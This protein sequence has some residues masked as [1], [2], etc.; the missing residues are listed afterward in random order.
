[1]FWTLTNVNLP[2]LSLCLQNNK[3]PHIRNSNKIERFPVMSRQQYSCSKTR[4]GDHFGVP[5]TVLWALNSIF[6]QKSSFVW[7][8]Y[9]RGLVKWVETL[10]WKTKLHVVLALISYY[11]LTVCALFIFKQILLQRMMKVNRQFKQMEYARLEECIYGIHV[12]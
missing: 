10:S 7:V 2:R 3:W 11:L 12:T 9:Y 4:N 6:M 5:K 1:M 8:N